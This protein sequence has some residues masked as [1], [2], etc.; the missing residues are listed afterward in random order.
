[1]TIEN[2]Y[3]LRARVEGAVASG[4]VAADF[5]LIAED[6]PTAGAWAHD[7]CTSRGWTF[8]SY[9][10]LAQT[11][12]AEGLGGEAAEAARAARANGYAVVLLPL[13]AGEDE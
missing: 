2:L 7:I 12:E 6:G 5:Y 8:S 11:L 9:L 13:D 4:P 3:Y 10:A 1:M